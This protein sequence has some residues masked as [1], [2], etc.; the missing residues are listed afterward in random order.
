MQNSSKSRWHQS[1]KRSHDAFM[2]SE[3]MDAAHVLLPRIFM[4]E[5]EHPECIHNPQ[6]ASPSSCCRLQPTEIDQWPWSNRVSGQDS[7]SD[8]RSI[9]TWR[10]KFRC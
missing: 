1:L 2:H 5:L 6:N 9:R 4:L 7:T 8:H 3:V 10:N